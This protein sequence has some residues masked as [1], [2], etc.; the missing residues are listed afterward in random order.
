MVLGLVRDANVM[1][2][3]TSVKIDR[4]VL[5]DHLIQLV[6]QLVL[7]MKVQVHVQLVMQLVDIA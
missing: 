2:V 7:L 4:Y 3:C 6:G 5:I 1:T